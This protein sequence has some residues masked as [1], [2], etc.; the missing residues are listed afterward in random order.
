[1]RK[2][3]AL[4]AALA[5][6]TT[7]LATPAAAAQRHHHD[8]PCRISG[9]PNKEDCLLQFVLQG[10]RHDSIPGTSSSLSID[11]MDASQNGYMIGVVTGMMSSFNSGGP[12]EGIYTLQLSN[13]KG[14]VGV[15]FATNSQQTTPLTVTGGSGIFDCA[16]GSGTGEGSGGGAPIHVK[17]HLRFL[18]TSR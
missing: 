8:R 7:A 18:C 14:Q 9:R 6:A 15:Q 12:G 4:A 17:L 16:T 10:T 1:M 3:V 11:T 2:T 5:A 13:G